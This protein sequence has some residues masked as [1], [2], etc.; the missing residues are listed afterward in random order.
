[1]HSISGKNGFS[2]GV[3]HYSWSPFDGTQAHAIYPALTR[4]SYVARCCLDPTDV[5]RFDFGVMSVKI[6]ASLPI[7]LPDL[8]AGHTEGTYQIKTHGCL[9][10]TILKRRQIWIDD[11]SIHIFFIR[12]TI[13]LMNLYNT[14]DFRWKAQKIPFKKKNA[15][16][17]F[18]RPLAKCKSCDS[19]TQE[20]HQVFTGR[21]KYRS[22]SWWW[23]REK[24]RTHSDISSILSAS[25]PTLDFL[26][27]LFVSQTT[28][29]G[30]SLFSVY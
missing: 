18:S 9:F 21:W 12:S 3:F 27:N 26:W 25:S 19:K 30:K 4:S 2:S 1:M 7:P 29:I 22:I 10:M 14:K 11:R 16:G 23:G 24:T 5:A 20:D 13:K 15:T 6:Q 17:W 28:Y 8:E